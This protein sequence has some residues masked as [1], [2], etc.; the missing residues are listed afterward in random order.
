MTPEFQYHPKMTKLTKKDPNTI[1]NLTGQDLERFYSGVF[2]GVS[3]IGIKTPEEEK[4][5][6]GN[7]ATQSTNNALEELENP[8]TACLYV[9]F[10]Q[11]DETRI[12]MTLH[13]KCIGLPRY[14]DNSVARICYADCANDAWIEAV[15]ENS[16]KT[17]L[18][19]DLI[20]LLVK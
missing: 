10:N 16:K 7:G 8:Q 9:T 3:E 13:N 4:Y 5:I 12:L 11:N 1:L 15:F 17:S 19:E 20:A 14:L 18:P 6:F 2:G